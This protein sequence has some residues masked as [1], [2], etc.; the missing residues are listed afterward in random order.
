MRDIVY[1]A[2][3]YLLFHRFKTAILLTSITLILFV[4]ERGGVS[5]S[6]FRK[7]WRNAG[8]RGWHRQVLVSDHNAQRSH[9]IALADMLEAAAAREKPV[10]AG[11]Q[12]K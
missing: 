12:A 10:D 9:P 11:R 2:W 3:R 1:L 6:G 5:A 8:D 7:S 4:P